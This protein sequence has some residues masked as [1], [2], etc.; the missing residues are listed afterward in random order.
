MVTANA[1]Q[2][3]VDVAACWLPI[4][5]L[6]ETADVRRCQR[7]RHT[8]SSALSTYTLSQSQGMGPEK[9]VVR[10]LQPPTS[11]LP[12]PLPL[13][14]SSYGHAGAGIRQPARK[15]AEAALSAKDL[16]IKQAVA[17]R[18]ERR[19]AKDRRET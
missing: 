14:V 2:R 3:A 5:K 16:R 10:A 9:T 15:L 1:R 7:I 13:V 18:T 19:A 12:L 11:L 6:K 4:E 8:P 17:Q